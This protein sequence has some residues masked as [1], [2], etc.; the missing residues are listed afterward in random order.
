MSQVMGDK[1]ASI[2]IL[3]GQLRA[4]HPALV[5]AEQDHAREHLRVVLIESAA[6]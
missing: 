4:R 6:R 1:R 3:G 2:W 5:A